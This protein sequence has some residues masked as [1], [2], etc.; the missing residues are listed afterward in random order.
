MATLDSW[1]EM[2]ISKL[3]D[4]DEEH[5]YFRL[6]PHYAL[7]QKSL[8]AIL[9]SIP[10]VEDTKLRKEKWSFTILPRSLG[11]CSFT[12]NGYIFYA[13]GPSEEGSFFIRA[14]DEDSLAELAYVKRNLEFVD[15][16]A[17]RND[18]TLYLGIALAI[19]AA[20]LYLWVKISGAPIGI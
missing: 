16:S 19:V 2:R 12:V 17:Y 8:M 15:L 20:G 11:F 18:K 9:S 13:A 5:G 6:A 7:N 14:S 10:N 4:E 3:T 1:V